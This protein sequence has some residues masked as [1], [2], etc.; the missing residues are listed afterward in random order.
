MAYERPWHKRNKDEAPLALMKEC[1]QAIEDNRPRMSIAMQYASAFEGS[2]LTSFFPVGYAF[3]S[4]N[5]FPGLNTPQLRRKLRS[6]VKGAHAQLWGN[7]D[8]LPQWMSVGGDWSTQTQAIL[9]NRAIDAEYEQPQGRFDNQHDLWRHA[10]LMAMACTG[11]VA[12]FELPGWGKTEARINDTLTMA[13]ETSGPNG[14]YLG[15]IGTD[16][17]EVEELCL[18]FPRQREQIEKNAENMWTLAERRMNRSAGA[19]PRM[20]TR[21]VSQVHL[22]YRCSVRG[23]DGRKLWI[24][25]DGTRLGKDEVY[26]YEEL[27]CTIFHFE[28]Q[29]VGDWAQP[30]S[31]YVHEVLRRQNEMAHDADQKQIN[32][33]QR[34]VQGPAE[35]LAKIAGKTKATME[36][37]SGSLMTDVRITECDSRDQA[38]LA[39]IELYGRWADEDAMVDAR[40]QGGAGKQATSGKHEKY[41]AS[42]FTE[43][44]APESRRIIHCR[45]VQTGK[46]KV[47]ALK[48]MVKDGQD[49]MRRWE[50]GSLSEVIDVADLDLDE[51]KFMLRVASVSEEKNSISSLLD[52]G[53]Q[54]V[55]QEK[56][57]LAELQQWRQHLDADSIGDAVTRVQQWLEK[58]IEKWL[59]AKDKERLSDDFYQS[60]RKWMDPLERWAEK[61]QQAM[62]AAESM[63]CPPDRLEYFE[64]FLEEIGVLIDQR[65]MQ[66]KTS[67]SATADL[68]QIYP[69]QAGPP[70]GAMNATGPGPLPPSGGL[71]SLGPAP[72][73]LPALG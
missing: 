56:A 35:T 67:I 31:A 58:Q 39:M 66:S 32:S 7:D 25:K 16:Y 41:N 30:L 27:P 70:P 11:S 46:R 45:T 73:A 20:E 5:V 43:A 26:E 47:R 40:H 1:Q 19:N 24:L 3:T 55:E 51:N 61:V 12:V 49:I 69:G 52:F 50:K 37:E 23:E 53:Q 64:L 15:C 8:P 63:G 17:Y 57:S 62:V 28:R 59:H 36:I 9:L 4:T 72:G 22:G 68:S 13:V 6:I 34:I 29:M 60:P 54:M 2:L 44:F 21:W 14:A 33:P 65:D 38:A 42:Y 48:D 10:G 18:R 71:P